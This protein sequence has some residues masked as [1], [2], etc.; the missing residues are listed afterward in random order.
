M[1]C[2]WVTEEGLFAELTEVFL[3]SSCLIRGDWTEEL[4]SFAFTHRWN[5]DKEDNTRFQSYENS[6]V[7]KLHTDTIRAQNVWVYS[8]TACTASYFLC[9]PAPIIYLEKAWRKISSVY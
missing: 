6:K 9:T 7:H 4:S 5:V 1:R 8:V 3:S 2:K